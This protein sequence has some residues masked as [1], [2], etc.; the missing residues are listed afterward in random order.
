MNHHHP[1]IT[2]NLVKLLK[3][4]NSYRGQITHP[5]LASI[6]RLDTIIIKKVAAACKNRA[7]S[8]LL[9]LDRSVGLLQSCNSFLSV[10]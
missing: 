10:T 6:E 8:M 5:Y 3:L 1:N 7:P 4:Q 2:T 9:S